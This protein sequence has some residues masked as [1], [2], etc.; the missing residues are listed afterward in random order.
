M[1]KYRYAEWRALYAAEAGLNDVGIIVLPQIAGDTLLLAGGVDY[2][3]DENGNPIGR[4]G[5]CM[6]Y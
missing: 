1:E 6:F 3:E 4:Y 2:G 5:Y